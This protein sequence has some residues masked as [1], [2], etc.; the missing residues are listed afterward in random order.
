M[1]KKWYALRVKPHKETAVKERLEAQGTELYLP[2]LSVKPKNP[3]AAKQKPYFPGYMFIKAD[4]DHLG[5]HAFSWLP[6]TLGLVSFGD[7]PAEVPAGFIVELQQTLPQTAALRQSLLD[8][9]KGEKVQ[10]IGGP[11]AGYAAIFDTQLSGSDRVQLLIAFLSQHPHPI[12][13]GSELI[14]KYDK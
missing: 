14:E 13:I 3:R 8:F 9:K 2:M 10:I 7:E 6:G 11:F 12:R 5:Q 1:A 4:L